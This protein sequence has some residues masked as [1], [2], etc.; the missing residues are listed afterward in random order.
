MH[1]ALKGPGRVV[2]EGDLLSQHR[3][4]KRPANVEETPENEEAFNKLLREIAWYWGDAD[5]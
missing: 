2:F 5:E 1:R 4:A 3:S